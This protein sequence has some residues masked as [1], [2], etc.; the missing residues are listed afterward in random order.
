MLQSPMRLR[1]E[2]LAALVPRSKKISEADRGTA[3]D[4]AQGILRF[5]AL[6]FPN[7]E[8][9]IVCVESDPALP[10]MNIGL[11][12]PPNKPMF[13]RIVVGGIFDRISSMPRRQYASLDGVL[14]DLSNP[15]PNTAPLY[16][17]TLSLS[18]QVIRSR[19]QVQVPGLELFSERNP[20]LETDETENSFGRL[21]F[22]L[23]RIQTEQF[24]TERQQAEKAGQDPRQ[25]RSTFDER[26]FD[27]RFI[28]FLFLHRYNKSTNTGDILEMLHAQP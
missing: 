27:S 23:H 17:K 28:G 7:D 6:V 19:L 16:T 3:A 5:H 13:Y 25:I 12:E 18:A 4:I 15:K 10:L 22:E 11:V 1:V 20:V 21:K 2:Q 14:Y 8:P 26:K 9:I 24:K